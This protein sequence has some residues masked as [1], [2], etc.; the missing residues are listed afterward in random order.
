MKLAEPV[1]R[2]P[3][4]CGGQHAYIG[5]RATLRSVLASLADGDSVEQTLVI[6][7]TLTAEQVRA[8]IPFAA[9]SMEE[10]QPLPELPRPA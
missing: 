3:G 5:T 1:H 10:D 8:T 7:P 4:L 2:D 9:A 6:F